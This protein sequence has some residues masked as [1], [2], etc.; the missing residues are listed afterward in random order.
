MSHAD[1]RLQELLEIAV[2]EPPG[3]ISLEAVRHIARRRRRLHTAAT[4]VAAA[5]ACA[6]V[7]MAAAGIGGLV[8]SQPAASGHLAP[9]VPRFYVQQGP[10]A[11]VGF[12]SVNGRAVVRDTAT[13][14]ITAT[15]RCPWTGAAIS[16]R[17]AAA[18]H[19]S[20]FMACLRARGTALHPT[21]IG[22]RIYRFRVTGA[23]TV[24][25]YSLVA[26][27]ALPGRAVEGLAAAA[28]GSAIAMRTFQ[29][30]LLG[31]GTVLVINTRTGAHASW[32]PTELGAAAED[33]SLSQNGRELRFVLF[34]GDPQRW[35]LD[36][37]SLASRGGRL[38][39][40]HVLVD[41]PAPELISYAQVS[42]DGSVLTVAWASL[43]P[44]A[45]NAEVT[46]EQVSTGSGKVIRV[47]FRAAI[48]MS[49]VHAGGF[50]SRASS[51]SSGRYI[52]VMYGTT[53]SHRNGWIDHGRLVPLTPPVAAAGLYET[54]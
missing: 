16:G 34:T 1:T 6:A 35:V 29:S 38:G 54:W 48:R 4:A 14:A 11:V 47:L 19:E 36:Q 27:A 33:L 37:V 8:S 25:G 45:A 3:T 41:I 21:L 46:V 42:P 31:G 7:L 40:P 26:G 49:G 50:G 12:V 28:D 5:V 22:S 30:P 15:V 23:G 2:G 10:A 18:G 32:F 24:D 17:I 9:G 53:V 44:R 20:F 13:G 51:D 52:I 43:A 39:N